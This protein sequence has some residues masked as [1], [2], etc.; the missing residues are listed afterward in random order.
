MKNRKGNFHRQDG[1]LSRCDFMYTTAAVVIEAYR[2]CGDFL[3]LCFCK[4]F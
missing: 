1:K 4:Y 3:A 2:I